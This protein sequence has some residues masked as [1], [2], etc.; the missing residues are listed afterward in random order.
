MSSPPSIIWIFKLSCGY[1]IFPIQFQNSASRFC[2]LRNSTSAGKNQK[3][4]NV[5]QK[6]KKIFFA[7]GKNSQQATYDWS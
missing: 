1:Y 5:K 2:I 6:D 4:Y 7:L 3:N